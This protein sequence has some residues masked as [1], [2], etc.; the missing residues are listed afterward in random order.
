M[1]NNETGLYNFDEGVFNSQWFYDKE[2]LLYIVG[3]LDEDFYQ[4]PI[5]NHT[6]EILD[7]FEKHELLKLNRKQAK[8]LG[9]LIVPE[10]LKRFDPYDGY[11]TA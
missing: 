4:A 1:Y 6:D 7:F 5:G 2:G 3:R 9:I 11:Y 10:P 8:K